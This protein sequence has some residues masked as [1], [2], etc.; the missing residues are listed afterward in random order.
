MEYLNILLGEFFWQREIRRTTRTQLYLVN[1]PQYVSRFSNQFKD[2]SVK[3]HL[4][5][6]FI[7]LQVLCVILHASTLCLLITS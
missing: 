3:K 4:Q 6:I 2:A 5:A 1:L 7:L